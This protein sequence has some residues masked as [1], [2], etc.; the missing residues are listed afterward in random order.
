M[1]GGKSCC[2]CFL[3]NYPDKLLLV[4]AWGDICCVN[5]TDIQAEMLV[6]PRVPWRRAC[7]KEL[8]L[9]A[10]AV[11]GGGWAL[12]SLWCFFLPF[13]SPEDVGTLWFAH[14]G[15]QCC[16]CVQ[17]STRGFWPYFPN[18]SGWTWDQGP[19]AVF[20]QWIIWGAGEQ[21]TQKLL[22]SVCALIL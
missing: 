4:L 5:D 6:P 15:S 21:N 16:S 14:S 10:G 19:W 2:C 11:W 17:H 12:F 9:P 18:P 7:S 20:A 8:L 1:Y 3:V 22:H 13:V